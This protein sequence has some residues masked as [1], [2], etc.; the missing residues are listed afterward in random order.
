MK[1]RGAN[2]RS[3][4]LGQAFFMRKHHEA[5]QQDEIA[6]PEGVALPPEQCECGPCYPPNGLE[7]EAM[8][9]WCAEHQA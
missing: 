3:H 7:Q 5:E 6:K 1:R 4:W 8:E 9:N 2:E